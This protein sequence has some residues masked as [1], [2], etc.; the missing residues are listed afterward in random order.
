MTR[1]ANY[2]EVS[3]KIVELSK[4]GNVKAIALLLD[5]VEGSVAQQHEVTGA[6]GESLF[7]GLTVNF[8][9]LPNSAFTKKDEGK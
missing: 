5:R 1:P 7:S 2:A 9:I 6:D 8:N 3:R 4:N